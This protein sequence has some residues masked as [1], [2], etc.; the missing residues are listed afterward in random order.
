MTK[1]RILVLMSGGVDSVCTA[2]LASRTESLDAMLFVD[3]GQPSVEQERAAAQWCSH[4]LKVPLYEL[5]CA[6]DASA[7]KIGV[8][9]EG[10]RV[11]PGR[12]AVLLALAMHCGGA[13]GDIDRIWIGCTREDFAGYADCRPEFLSAARAMAWA[14]G[15][16]ARAPLAACS[17]A[18]VVQ[19][20]EE[21]GVDIGKCWSCYE[22]REGEACGACNS[23]RQ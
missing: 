6:L 23:C 3:Y 22:P 11:V 8:G 10:A 4:D 9:E 16:F 2:H 13:L 17:R 14:Y 18:D 1:K 19:C 15:M 21:W 12:N 20:L 7:L 5:R